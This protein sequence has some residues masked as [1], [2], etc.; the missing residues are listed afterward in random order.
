MGREIR[1]V[2]R[3]GFGRDMRDVKQL[4][5]EVPLAK[6]YLWRCPAVS[7]Q[8]NPPEHLIPV[9]EELCMGIVVASAS[10]PVLEDRI[11]VIAV[12]MW[13]RSA[14]RKPKTCR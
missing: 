8:P 11:S 10:S 3:I 6:Y 7:T 14:L 2:A 12:K 4:T 1:R 9:T 5:I 13:K